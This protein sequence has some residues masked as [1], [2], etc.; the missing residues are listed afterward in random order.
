M[1]DY[2]RNMI[3]EWT[4]NITGT[5]PTPAA[6]YLFADRKGDPP[7]KTRLLNYKLLLLRAY[8]YVYVK[9]LISISPFA[10]LYTHVQ[11]Y[12]TDYCKNMIRMLNY[13]NGTVKDNLVLLTYNIHVIKWYVN[14][15]FA[16]YPEFKIHTGCVM[17]LRDGTIQYIYCKKNINNR[18]ST[19]VEL[20][21]ANDTYTMILWTRLFLESQGYNIDKNI[22]YQDNNY[23]TLLEKNGKKISKK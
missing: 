8:L 3:D 13:L 19:K 12:T 4:E 9:Y 10:D 11:N 20:I 17:N 5:A 6:E 1:S 2:I 18:S 16:I 15:S 14:A 21:G 7:Q 22:L 23:T